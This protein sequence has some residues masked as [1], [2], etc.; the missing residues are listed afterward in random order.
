MKIIK[1]LKKHINGKLSLGENFDLYKNICSKYYDLESNPIVF[2]TIE[3]PDNDCSYFSVSIAL[4]IKEKNLPFQ[5]RL[6]INYSS[7]NELSQFNEVIW[8][9][10]VDDFFDAIKKIPSYYYINENHLKPIGIDILKVAI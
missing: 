7:N 4:Q 2:E 1:E 10:E 3:I 9:D 6:N 5:I 8:S